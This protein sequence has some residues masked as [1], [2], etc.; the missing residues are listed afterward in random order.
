MEITWYGHSC[1]R[2]KGAEAAVV[3]DPV[4]PETGYLPER[5]AAEIITISH[6]H[7]GHNNVAAV[8]GVRKTLRGPGEY[9]VVNV[10]VVGVATFH[11]AERGARLGLNT[12]FVIEMD[13][14]RVCHLGDL[15]HVPHGEQLAHLT[16]VD[17]LLV[18]VGGGSTIGATAAAEVINLIEPKLVVP[19]HYRTAA[20]ARPEL[21][22]PERFLKEM[23]LAAAEPQARLS[24]TRQG[25]PKDKEA[26]VIVLDYQR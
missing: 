6:D 14:V 12:A 7:P 10:L 20:C 3:T 15:G 26:R 23:G 11:D 24:V 9:E 16:S 5:L 18:P 19:M 13:G 21:E 25:L 1:F 8:S 4:G 2:L 22:G 17:V